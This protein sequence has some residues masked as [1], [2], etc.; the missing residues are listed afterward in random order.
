M[1]RALLNPM[2]PASTPSLTDR[3]ASAASIA[4]ASEDFAIAPGAILVD[5]DLS[6][7]DLSGAD[8][9]GAD[10]SHADLRGTNLLGANLQGATLF[11]VRAE[12]A[13]FAGANLTGANMVEG[14]FTAAGFGSADLTDARATGVTMNR[15][16]LV[17][18]RAGGADF[19]GAQLAETRWNDSYVDG[20]DFRR[21]DL[22]SADLTAVSLAGATFDDAK[23][24]RLRLSR[25]VG[26]RQ[27]SWIGLDGDVLDLRGAC[28]VH[29]FIQDQNF[30]AEYRS[31]GIGYEW[32]YRIWWL[33]S[34]CGRS[35]LRWT[36][37]SAFIALIFASI[38]TQ[39]GID[40]GPYETSISPIYFSVVTLTT[41]G[42]GDALPKTATAQMTVMAEVILGYVM[43]GGLLSLVSNKLSRRAS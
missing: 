40:Y 22:E 29:D 34:D 30:L 31:Q 36:M 20:A 15:S 28:F 12:S 38:Y 26:Y 24:N 41:L 21:A 8:L 32:T 18:C 11:R 17:G 4:H 10:L 39:V 23:V 1:W 25:V 37:C 42:F 13:E 35:V 43:L 2:A 33:T 9:R 27:A 6:G 19:V 14:D 16:T 5:A 7:R 3:D